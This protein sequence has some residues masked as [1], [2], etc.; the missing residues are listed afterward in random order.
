MATPSTV[1][2][3]VPVGVEPVTPVAMVNVKVSLVP[4]AGVALDVEIQVAVGIGVGTT[5]L[6]VSVSV[7]VEVVKAAEPE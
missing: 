3:I 6:T 4:S 5:L 7:P 1:S 2:A